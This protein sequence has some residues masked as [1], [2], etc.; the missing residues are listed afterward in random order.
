[1]LIKMEE[2]LIYIR[3]GVG[4]SSNYFPCVVL[5]KVKVFIDDAQGLVLLL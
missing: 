2:C 5:K 3:T 1:M 4:N